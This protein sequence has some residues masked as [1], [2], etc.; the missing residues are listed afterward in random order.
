MSPLVDPT[1]MMNMG[2]VA[3]VQAASVQKAVQIESSSPDLAYESLQVDA[4]KEVEKEASQ[5]GSLTSAVALNELND[6]EEAKEQEEFYEAQD[7][8]EEEELIE[9]ENYPRAS[10]PFVGNLLNLKV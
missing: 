8:D 1:G 2:L 7:K 10:D 3:H 6:E 4:L 9:E 5:L